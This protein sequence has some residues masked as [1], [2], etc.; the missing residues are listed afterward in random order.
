MSSSNQ[1]NTYSAKLTG[2]IQGRKLSQQDKQFLRTAMADPQIEYPV[3]VPDDVADST[4]MKKIVV[5]KTINMADYA[6]VNGTQVDVIL[7]DALRAEQMKRYPL[8]REAEIQS[9]PGA[10][11]FVGGVGVYV[12]TEDKSFFNLKT[13]DPNYEDPLNNGWGTTGRGDTINIPDEYLGGRCRLVGQSVKVVNEG[14]E[15]Y[16][17]G[18]VRAWEQTVQG[19]DTYYFNLEQT[20]KKYPDASEG[21]DPTFTKMWSPALQK[22][23]PPGT[24]AEIMA[25]RRTKLIGHAKDGVFI[26]GSPDLEDCGSMLPSLK[27]VVYEDAPILTSGNTGTGNGYYDRVNLNS[28]FGAV[29]G[30]PLFFEESNPSNVPALLGNN[31][32]G[33]PLRNYY[34]NG[35]LRGVRFSGLNNGSSGNPGPAVLRIQCTFYIEQVPSATDQN[36]LVLAKPSPPENKDALE[37][38]NDLRRKM[39]FAFPARYNGLGTFTKM[40][41]NALST[42]VGN[43]KFTRAYDKHVSK[44]AAKALLKSDY[45]KLLPG[46]TLG[47]ATAQFANAVHKNGNTKSEKRYLAATAAKEFIPMALNMASALTRKVRATNYSQDGHSIKGPDTQIGQIMNEWNNGGPTRTPQQNKK[48]LAKAYAYHLQYPSYRFPA[49]LWS[50]IQRLQYEAEKN[51]SNVTNSTQSVYQAPKSALKR[52]R[53][54]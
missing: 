8:V 16:Q 22:P 19:S 36:M 42:P 40:I 3:G 25:L 38:L 37:A 52:N 32:Y 20:I 45:V 12:H 15:T 14:P 39:D 46:G 17:S 9:E 1:G 5:E 4:V 6:G 35:T 48:L 54:G 50:Q 47:Q 13:T 49:A 31:M 26:V 33:A 11:I 29:K 43:N 18:T 30:L 7:W 27:T 41:T 2:A 24:N 44:P 34:T 28:R 51:N 23:P 10:S 21:A 53:G